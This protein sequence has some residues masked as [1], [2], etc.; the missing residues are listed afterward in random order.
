[1]A[2]FVTRLAERA[3]GEA[4]VVQP[5]I[6]PAFA[7]EQP[8][9]PSDSGWESEASPSPED[10]GHTAYHPTRQ[11]LAAPDAPSLAP[12]LPPTP[13]P[14]EV[15]LPDP[16]RLVDSGPAEPVAAPGQDRGADPGPRNPPRREREPAESD[17]LETGSSV[18]QEDRQNSSS[19]TTGPSNSAPPGPARRETGRGGR[20]ETRIT[21]EGRP[22]PRPEPRPGTIRRVEPGPLRRVADEAPRRPAPEDPPPDPPAAKNGSHRSVFR[23]DGTVEEPGLA[24]GAPSSGKVNPLVSGNEQGR[25]ATSPVPRIAP[26]IVDHSPDQRREQAPRETR[27]FAPEPPAPTIRV[28]IG[29]IEVRAITP[30]PAPPPRRESPVRSG[31]ALSLDDYLK[32]RNGGQR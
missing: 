21:T 14:Q 7:P 27:A 17:P 1:M 10:P 24:V 8:A 18:G 32:Q 26:R 2:D 31:P 28:A 4:P 6:P 23:Q 30:P 22:K 25:A 11:T 20:D 9:H 5:L 16:P 19:R 3:M 15:P 29:R 12:D 13:E